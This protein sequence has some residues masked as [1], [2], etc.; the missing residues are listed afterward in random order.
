MKHLVT[1]A[2]PASGTGKAGFVAVTVLP[3]FQYPPRS[4]ESVPAGLDPAFPDAGRGMPLKG[5]KLLGTGHA[6][7]LRD[8]N[9]PRIAPEIRFQINNPPGNWRAVAVKGENWTVRL[10]S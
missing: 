2:T 1:T 10:K 6:E 4:G 5:R 9:R 7:A 8:A 3:G